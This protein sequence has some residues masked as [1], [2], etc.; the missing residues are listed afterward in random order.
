V[1]TG[2]G[3]TA[4]RAGC[5]ATSEDTP[6]TTI[7]ISNHDD[8]EREDVDFVR[9]GESLRNEFSG[10]LSA[11]GEQFVGIIATVRATTEQDTFG[12]NATD[13]RRGSTW[14]PMERADSL[15]DAVVEAG[16]PDFE[17]ECR[18]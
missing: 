5:A 3:L 7:R 16:P 18:T 8:V 1:R 11:N 12:V 10:T 9:Q 17:T 2:T 4:A 13:G 14:E 15:V 6:T